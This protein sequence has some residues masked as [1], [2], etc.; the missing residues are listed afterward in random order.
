MTYDVLA[1]A[2]KGSAI[3]QP[4]QRHFSYSDILVVGKKGSAIEQPL[5]LVTISF[6]LLARKVQLQISRY[7]DIFL[8]YTNI[9]VVGKDQRLK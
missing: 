4:L 9:L 5:Q 8:F 3:A 2:K 6:Q 7:N 1:V